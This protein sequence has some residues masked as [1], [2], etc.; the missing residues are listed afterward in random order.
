MN[1]FIELAAWL[2]DLEPGFAFL[3]ALPFVVAVVGLLADKQ[4]S[5]RAVP[6][7][8]DRRDAG[9]APHRTP[10]RAP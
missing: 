9:L 3:L 2:G 10:V 4:R 1:P 5:H 6:T 8:V 7:A